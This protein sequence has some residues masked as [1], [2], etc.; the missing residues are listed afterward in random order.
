MLLGAR[1]DFGSVSEES[2]GVGAV[3]AVQSFEQVEISEPPTVKHQ[4]RAS[5]NL[6]DSK[7]WKADCLIDRQENI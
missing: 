3:D 7:D 6:G 4:I 5:L 2:V 1:S